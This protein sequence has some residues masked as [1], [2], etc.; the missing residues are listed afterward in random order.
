MNQQITQIPLKHIVVGDYQRQPSARRVE[1]IA[2]GFDTA[3]LGI[4]IV[5]DRQDGT[6]AMLDGQ[7]RLSALRTLGYTDANCLVLAGLTLEQEAD[8]YRRQN[9][10]HANLNNYDLYLAG[11][12]AGD[13]HYLKLKE[14]LGRYGYRAHNTS[15]P[16]NVTA[17]AAVTKIVELY[18][19]DVLDR[20]FAYI[21]AAWDG[22]GTAVRR[23]MLAGIADF[24]ARF[25]KTVTPEMFASRMG[26]K[27]PG[28]LFYEYRR[29]TEGRATSRNAFNPTMRRVCC[30][31]LMETYNRGLGSQSRNRL[32]MGD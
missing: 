31:I 23:E 19:F 2:A 22:D 9:E 21:C 5:N 26:N 30:V 11:V 3:K 7:H 16:K 27:I 20:T 4:L 32:H 12:V 1:R 24:A 25:G 8:Y 29:R 15:A 17:I 10:N 28:Q 13:P 18:G 14:T 6:Y